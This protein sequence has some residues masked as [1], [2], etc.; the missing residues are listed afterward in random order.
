[1]SS[2]STHGCPLIQYLKALQLACVSIS[3]LRNWNDVCFV[4]VLHEPSLMLIVF[5]RILAILLK[6][7][8]YVGGWTMQ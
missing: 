7:F 1:M 8:V 2:L 5:G 3:L 4:I 6:R